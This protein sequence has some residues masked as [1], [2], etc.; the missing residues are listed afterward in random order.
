MSTIIQQGYQNYLRTHKHVEV[1]WA[2]CL[3]VVWR[4]AASGFATVSLSYYAGG[5]CSLAGALIA[6]SLVVDTISLLIFRL[7]SARGHLR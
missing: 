6:R 3:V 5:H 2:A 7:S 1:D 4:P